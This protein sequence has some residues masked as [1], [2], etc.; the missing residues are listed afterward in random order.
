MKQMELDRNVSSGMASFLADARAVAYPDALCRHCPS[1]GPFLLRLLRIG[2]G[3]ITI[4]RSLFVERAASIMS[5]P[6][7]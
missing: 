1:P 5:P 6:V 2:I 3:V 7:H 4:L